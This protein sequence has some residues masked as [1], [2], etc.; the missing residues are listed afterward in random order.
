[1]YNKVFLNPESFSYKD[2]EDLI[3]EICQEK[4]SD[5]KFSPHIYGRSGQKQYG[6]DISLVDTGTQKIGIQCKRYDSTPF[7]ASEIISKVENEHLKLDKFIIAITAYR[8]KKISDEFA[9]VAKLNLPFKIEIWFW[10]DIVKFMSQSEKLCKKYNLL[11]VSHNSD[12]NTDVSQ[13]ITSGSEFKNIFFELF[14]KYKIP[15]FLKCDGKAEPFP[16]ELIV[17]A[18]C[19]ISDTEELILNCYYSNSNI[20]SK[21]SYINACQ[22]VCVFSEY[23]SRVACMVSP[24]S[25]GRFCIL[26]DACI[27]EFKQLHF[28]TIKCLGIIVESIKNKKPLNEAA[29]EEFYSY[30]NK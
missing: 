15:L 5:A 14:Q 10:E 24:S 1:M 9:N 21:K 29:L 22:Y 7:N 11:Y 30:L 17:N 23:H 16:M 13:Q 6:I 27:S 28:E 26:Q 20:T 8:D 19:F 18:D 2:F 25:N 3:T 4:Y 12:K